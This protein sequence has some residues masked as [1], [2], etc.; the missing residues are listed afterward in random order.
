MAGVVEARETD[1]FIIAVRIEAMMDTFAW[2]AGWSPV[3]PVDRHGHVMA[4]ECAERDVACGCDEAGRCL[5]A[6]CPACCRV[7]CVHGFGQDGAS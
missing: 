6:H 3:P 4:E 5:L 2:L 1:N 7:P